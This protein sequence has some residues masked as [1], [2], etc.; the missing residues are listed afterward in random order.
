MQNSSKIID[1]DSRVSIMQPNQMGILWQLK[2]REASLCE[3]DRSLPSCCE[4]KFQHDENVGILCRAG[5]KKRHN[6]K[7]KHYCPAFDASCRISM[8]SP[9]LLKLGTYLFCSMCYA[10][11][12]LKITVMVLLKMEKNLCVVPKRYVHNSSYMISQRH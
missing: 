7:P 8:N 9:T 1:R 10:C 5:D 6:P 3:L 2:D 4:N 11:S 12:C